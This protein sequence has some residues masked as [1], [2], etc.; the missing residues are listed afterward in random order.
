[1]ISESSLTAPPARRIL[2]QRSTPGSSFFLASATSRVITAGTVSD[3]AF[4][5]APRRA[6]LRR[7]VHSLS[8]LYSGIFRRQCR[9]HSSGISMSSLSYWSTACSRCRFRSG[10]AL[11]E[12]SQYSA[13]VSDL[14]SSTYF[15]RS[16][17]SELKN[18]P[19]LR[20]A[21][22]MRDCL[23]SRVRDAPVW[24]SA[25]SNSRAASRREMVRGGQ[26]G[27]RLPFAASG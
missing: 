25:I 17:S 6:I 10:D 27:M 21:T 4:F 12:I 19:R 7:R 15:R 13:T 11:N 14:G 23:C 1:M 24:R 22:A 2:R 16:G 20:R 8:S 5:G 9:R 26:V 18:T 3:D